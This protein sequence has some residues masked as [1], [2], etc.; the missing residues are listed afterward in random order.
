MISSKKG[1]RPV[2]QGGV[3][4]RLELELVFVLVV[5]PL[6]VNPRNPPMRPRMIGR[7][8]IDRIEKTS[9]RA[10]PSLR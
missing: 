2:D 10:L 7:N 3:Y 4:P 6:Y 8:C 5:V 1:V 9:T